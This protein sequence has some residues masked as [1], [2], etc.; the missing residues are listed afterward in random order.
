MDAIPQ[1]E[2]GLFPDETACERP[3]PSVRVNA[4]DYTAVPQITR[5]Q[6]DLAVTALACEM[7]SVTTVQLSHTVSPVVFSWAGNTNTHHALSHTPDGDQAN[8]NQLL[9]AEQWCASQFAYAIE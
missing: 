1:H 6:I 5:Q 7:T 9:R 2:V 4:L 8:L 3:P